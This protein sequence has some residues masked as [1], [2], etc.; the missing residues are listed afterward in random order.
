MYKALVK[1]KDVFGRIWTFNAESAALTQ[2]EAINELKEL[3][4][5]ELDTAQSEIEVQLLL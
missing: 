2:N 5:C 3:Y 1:N 4:A